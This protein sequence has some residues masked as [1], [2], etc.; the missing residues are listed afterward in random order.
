MAHRKKNPLKPVMVYQ[1]GMAQDSVFDIRNSTVTL[2]LFWVCTQILCVHVST[3]TVNNTVILA[4][5]S[6]I[7]LSLGFL[8]VRK[9]HRKIRIMFKKYHVKC[10]TDEEKF[11]RMLKCFN[12]SN[13]VCS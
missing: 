11:K 2:K 6:G 1:V 10:N 4:F 13:S 8:L 12:I 5:H 9:W 7:S 3:A